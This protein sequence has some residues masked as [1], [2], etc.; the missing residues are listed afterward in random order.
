[1]L[2]ASPNEFSVI[3]TTFII[4]QKPTSAPIRL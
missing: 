2:S 3:N 4:G 1:M